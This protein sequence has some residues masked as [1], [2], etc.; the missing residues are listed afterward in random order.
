MAVRPGHPMVLAELPDG[1][2]LVGLPGNPLAAVAGA[3]TLA[4]P[5]L[6]RLGGRAAGAP[7][8]LP[9][10]TDLPGHP[11]DTRLVPVRRTEHGVLPL[12]FDGPAMLRGLVLADALAVVAPGGVR[13]GA[14]VEL[15][16][17]P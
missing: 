10:A 15:L 11:H 7:R 6:H 9:A 5:L 3:V 4:L 14:V 17:V 13:A 16:P 12:A 2:H 1:R 8:T